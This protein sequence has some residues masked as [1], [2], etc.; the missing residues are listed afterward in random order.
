MLDLLVHLVGLE[1][2]YNP[3]DL[4][5]YMIPGVTSNFDSCFDPKEYFGEGP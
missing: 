1:E 3:K 5:Q 4:Y 2:R